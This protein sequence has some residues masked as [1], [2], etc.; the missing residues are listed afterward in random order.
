MVL[1]Y[2]T[3]RRSN[4]FL[5]FHEYSGEEKPSCKNCQRQG[6]VCD[7]S[8]RLN[9]EGRSKRRATTGL[10]GFQP[11]ASHFGSVLSLGNVASD[12]PRSKPGSLA[13]AE[14]VAGNGASTGNLLLDDMASSSNISLRN[15]SFLGSS[16]STKPQNHIWYEN[17]DSSKVISPPSQLPD[18]I[19]LS[20]SPQLL[21][22]V[23]PSEVVPRY[24]SSLQRPYDGTSYPSPADTTSS[25]GSDSVLNTAVRPASQSLLD[26]RQPVYASSHTPNSPHLEIDDPEIRRQTHHSLPRHCSFTANPN[27]P[28]H[29]NTFT[30][31]AHETEVNASYRPA[32]ITSTTPPGQE[33]D[34]A[35]SPTNLSVAQEG[36]FSTV[37]NKPISSGRH[38]LHYPSGLHTRPP[39][40]IEETDQFASAST[41]ESKWHT[42][43]TTVTDNYG[44][45]CGRPDLDLN[46]NNDHAAI[47]V[48]YALDLISSMWKNQSATPKSVDYEKEP[49]E[50]NTDRSR[51]TYY[52][53]PVPINIPRYL[54]PLPSSLL[55]N[56]IN[57]MY[58]HFFLNKT[59]TLLV[60]HNCGLNPF[61]SVMPSSKQ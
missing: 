29:S 35:L 19:S 48:N 55:E 2:A 37:I 26:S 49:Q 53:S 9:W 34:A 10:P 25:I 58:F 31:S 52:A 50:H 4:G 24:N 39:V 12:F 30:R 59:A 20:S 17:K 18:P 32:S 22:T 44:L 54:S 41:A 7:Y 1:L 5:D 38:S 42:Y 56:P 14:T 45:D 40:L 8:I 46:R 21:S 11:S 3:F 61:I 60:P 16:C 6:E 57:L 15:L 28:A 27:H 23:A 43:L 51:Y 47:D 13:H 33:E 36:Y